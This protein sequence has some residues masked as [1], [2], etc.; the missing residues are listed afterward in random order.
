MQGENIKFR[1]IEGRLYVNSNNGGMGWNET[2]TDKFTVKSNEP[3]KI[4]VSIISSRF[5]DGE[6][7]ETPYDFTLVKEDGAKCRYRHF[8]PYTDIPVMPIFLFVYTISTVYH[9]C[10]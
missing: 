4:V 5:E 1:D 10:H 6:N 9:K 8:A 3:E 7:K 2:L